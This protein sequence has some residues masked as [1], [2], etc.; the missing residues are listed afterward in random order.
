VVE[1]QPIELVF[2]APDFVAVG[3]HPPVT[4]VGVLHDLVDEK[5]R[6]AS[7]VEASNP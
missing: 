6:V 7:S 5:L 2:Q 3:F 1:L 4:A